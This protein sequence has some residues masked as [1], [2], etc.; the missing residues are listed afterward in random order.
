M[1]ERGEVDGASWGWVS[2]N[3]RHTFN[4]TQIQGPGLFGLREKGAESLGAGG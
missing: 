3:P 2:P 1:G 4:F